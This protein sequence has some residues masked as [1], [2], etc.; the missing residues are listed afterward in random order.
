LPSG[1][2]FDNEIDDTGIQDGGNGQTLAVGSSTVT[3]FPS[4]GSAA[5]SAV[6]YPGF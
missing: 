3:I 1:G 2:S 5:K 6:S 4:D